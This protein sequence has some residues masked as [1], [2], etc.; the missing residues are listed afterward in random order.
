MLS[1]I[2][3]MSPSSCLYMLDIGQTSVPISP[4][5]PIHMHTSL[6]LGGRK[7]DQAQQRILGLV[8]LQGKGNAAEK[9]SSIQH[10]KSTNYREHIMGSC[11]VS[12]DS[13]YTDPN[14]LNS[15]TQISF[16]V[17]PR[18]SQVCADEQETGAG[19]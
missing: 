7:I 18:S 4:A 2:K 3:K 14:L 11:L 8:V 10:R 17:V 6:M 19:Y 1:K 15:R 9:G 12:G 16:L 13:L 5:F